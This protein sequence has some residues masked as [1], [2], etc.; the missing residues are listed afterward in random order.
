MD[1]GNFEFNG[2]G[3]VS[4]SLVIIRDIVERSGTLTTYLSVRLLD[5][6]LNLLR[7]GLHHHLDL[8]RASDILRKLS[9]M[10]YAMLVSRVLRTL[11]VPALA[12]YDK[13]I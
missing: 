9:H 4:P 12:S 5:V 2:D 7:F 8:I 6:F 3:R 10:I 13:T 1:S 11:E